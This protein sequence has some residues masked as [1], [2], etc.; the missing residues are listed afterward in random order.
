M[1][2]WLALSCQLESPR[3]FIVFCLLWDILL[4]QF[5]PFTRVFVLDLPA[6]FMNHTYLLCDTFAHTLLPIW[7]I[8]KMR[9]Y[10]QIAG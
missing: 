1:A 4:S 7:R 9:N 10:Q 8:S 2:I 3:H 5:F 6:P